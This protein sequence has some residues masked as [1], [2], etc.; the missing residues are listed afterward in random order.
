MRKFVTGLFVLLITTSVLSGCGKKADLVVAEVGGKRITIGEL[1][2]ALRKISPQLR[3]GT[4]GA[5][6]WRKC[7][8]LLINKELMLL[9]AKNQGLD[10]D[11]DV[12]DALKEVKRDLMVKELYKR[13]V[14]SKAKVSDEQARRYFDRN[15]L[16]EKIRL[17][18]IAVET[19]AEAQQI[20][21]ELKQGGDFA[22]LAREKSI[23]ESSAK[24]GGD[25]GW[26][27]RPELNSRFREMLFSMDAG[28]ICQPFKSSFGY[29][30]LKVADKK[31]VK[32]NELKR[33]IKRRLFPEAVAKRGKEYYS[34]L[35][36]ENKLQYEAQGLR[37]FLEA[38]RRSGQKLPEL[39][40]EE[41]KAVLFTFDGGEI[42]LADFIQ[43]F[44]W[45]GSQSC[46]M[47][48]DSARWKARAEMVAFEHVL[49]PQAAQKKGLDRDKKIL[50]QLERRR[51][52]FMVER[53]REIQVVD[54]VSITED[55]E[56]E[57]FNTHRGEY[58]AAEEAEIIDILLEDKKQA[59][60]I[61]QQIKKGADIEKLAEKYST[62]KRP[63]QM[64]WKFPLT[65]DRWSE[66]MFGKRFVE[67]VF[68]SKTGEVI[69]P[70]EA[71]GGYAVF[72]VLKKTPQRQQ[73]FEEVKDAI[74]AVLRQKEEQRR[75]DELI[76]N[77]REKYRQEIIIYEDALKELT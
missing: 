46:P 77:L 32:F 3:Q 1:Y 51:E 2:Q 52:E 74:S 72:K 50:A 13:E 22:E 41:R 57:Y 21:R 10:K 19:E 60:A 75:L 73:S 37:V 11:Q 54:K 35:K 47:V 33:R 48:G 24:K 44:R 59:E 38:Q 39:S 67:A 34:S 20:F 6:Q 16:N 61:L 58:V 17:S 12:L 64:R 30:I 76:E 14:T 71:K 70:V 23:D 69:G 8:D 53:L 43:A 18:H 9:E 36:A 63:K 28:Q 31:K 62:L 49:L 25:L 45:T 26:F 56:R 40:A 5:E 68:K 66:R 55:Q 27:I 7:L 29:S 4:M 15:R 65:N 42:T